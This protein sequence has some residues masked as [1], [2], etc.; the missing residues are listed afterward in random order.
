MFE[1]TDHLTPTAKSTEH[2]TEGLQELS[3]ISPI[4]ESQESS[5]YAMVPHTIYRPSLK[6]NINKNFDCWDDVSRDLSLQ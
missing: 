6:I 3:L 5:A 4:S 2:S 1:N